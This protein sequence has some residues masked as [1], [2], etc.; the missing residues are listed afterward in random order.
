MKRSEYGESTTSNNSRKRIDSS[1]KPQ[2]RNTC[3]E[4][5]QSIEKITLPPKNIK[6]Y[7]QFNPEHISKEKN[8]NIESR[9]KLIPTESRKKYLPKQLLQ[10]EKKPEQNKRI[11]KKPEKKQK[12]KLPREK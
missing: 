2:K 7:P 11:N 8:S 6:E 1:Q 5:Q 12:E 9:E 3:A 4:V 10:K